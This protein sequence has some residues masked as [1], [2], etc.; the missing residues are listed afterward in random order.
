LL[1]F[2]GSVVLGAC[3]SS[4]SSGPPGEDAGGD[5][6]A[7]VE[8]PD[9]T[10]GPPG[11]TIDATVDT[12][13]PA[14]S[15]VPDVLSESAPPE[16]SAGEDAG[17]DGAPEE[18]AV[19][20]PVDTGVTCGNVGCS[21]VAGIDGGSYDDSCSVVCSNFS[22]GCT[23]SDQVPE[24]CFCGIG[25]AAPSCITGSLSDCGYVPACSADLSTDP[26]NCG[27]CGHSCQG[28]ACTG[29]I[30][31]PPQ[32][33]FGPPFYPSDWASDGTYI[34][35]SDCSGAGT[36][37]RIPAGGVPSSGA[38]LVYTTGS[39]PW[40]IA[41]DASS[42]YW[43]QDSGGTVW[44]APIGGGSPTQLGT[45]GQSWFSGC[46]GPHSIAT[47]A[48]NLYWAMQPFSGFGYVFTVPK[49]GGQVQVLAHDAFVLR[50]TLA[51]DANNVYFLS[52]DGGENGQLRSVPKT[53]LNDAGTPSTILATFPNDQVM[54]V[55][56][57]GSTFYVG[58]DSTSI[59][60]V[61]LAGGTPATFWAGY[62]GLSPR[63]IDTDGTTLFFTD[64]ID[65]N[66]YAKPFAGGYAQR[67]AVGQTEPDYILV[68]ANSV[69]W[70]SNY[71]GYYRV[72][73]TYLP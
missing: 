2:S 34:Y 27:R 69:Y 72:P 39:G 19:D 52:Y 64:F 73:K 62:V 45:Y 18:A 40:G 17:E 70:T 33:S 68:D 21:T 51:V 54:D 1:A 57:V 20:A 41:I 47:D 31:T 50:G 3:F 46:G 25:N 4:S 22:P 67:I 24:A 8:A 12:T 56:L 7:A 38:P 60:D 44:S 11:S 26:Q 35:A 28:L 58:G 61:P 48:N 65:G 5:D 71:G 63:Y 23:C 14:E 9:A 59:Y 49:A 36:V 53:T 42:V 55:R 29:G 43:L 30:C 15:S 16:A 37:I 32:L 13:V 66:V 10:D 6:L